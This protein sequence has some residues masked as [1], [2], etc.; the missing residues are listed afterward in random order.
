M[1]ILYLRKRFFLMGTLPA[2]KIRGEADEFGG[3]VQLA[4][5]GGGSPCAATFH[6]NLIFA[7]GRAMI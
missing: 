7:V 4:S 2:E 6:V 5:N 1:L 3:H